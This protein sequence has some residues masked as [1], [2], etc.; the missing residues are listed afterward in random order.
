MYTYKPLL[1]LQLFQGEIQFR[2][3]SFRLRD[4]QCVN[5]WLFSSKLAMLICYI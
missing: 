3:M 2:G 1:T 4:T 5:T